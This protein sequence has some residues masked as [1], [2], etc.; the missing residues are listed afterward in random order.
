MNNEIIKLKNEYLSKLKTSLDKLPKE[1][2]EDILKE[3]DGYIDDSISSSS[4]LEDA[5]KVLKNLGEPHEYARKMVEQNYGQILNKGTFKDNL[6]IFWNEIWIPLLISGLIGIGILAFNTVLIY[7]SFL[8]QSKFLELFSI[9]LLNIPAILI[10]IIPIAV[11]I[12]VAIGFAKFLNIQE[13][14]KILKSY[15][16]WMNILFIGIA[17][18]LFSYAVND[19][20]VPSANYKTVEMYKEIMKADHPNQV[21]SNRLSP[22]EMPSWQLIQEIKNMK[23]DTQDTILAI[24]SLHTKFSMPAMCFVCA[25]F[26]AFIGIL[27]S[28]G[29]FNKMTLYI[30]GG[31]TPSVIFTSY[32]YSSDTVLSSWMP[33]IILGLF[34][35]I[36][37]LSIF[38]ADSGTSKKLIKAN[39]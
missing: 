39:E 16:I 33:V 20:I 35:I 38:G 29:L 25:F 8:K 9:I 4:S 3:I 37:L 2:R 28:T 7:D 11:S 24:K 34:E 32:Y 14:P 21:Y 10:P 23:P 19:L 22:Q 18:T 27:I 12:S 17:S 26:G 13:N 15:K 1:Q 6:K 30:F 31:L 5:Q 36:Y